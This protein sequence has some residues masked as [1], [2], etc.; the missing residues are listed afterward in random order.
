MDLCTASGERFVLEQAINRGGEAQIWTIRQDPHL[1]AKIY[2]K[3]TADHQAKLKAMLAAPLIRQGSHPAVAW[4]LDLLYGQN[5]FVGYLM[6]RANNCRP[7]FHYYNPARRQRLTA[8]QDWPR[9][10]HY[11]AAN[12]AR[13]V[14]TVHKGGHVIGDLNESNVL[15]T[16]TALVTLVDTDSFQIQQGGQSSQRAPSWLGALPGQQIYRCGVGKAEYTAPELQGVDFKTIDRTVAHDNFGLAVLI[17]YLLMDGFHP[18]AGVLNT[19][20]SVGRV[21]LYGI[22]QGLFPYLQWGANAKQAIQPP[23]KAP[24]FSYLHPGVQDAFRRTFVDGH[25]NP[26]RRVTAKEWKE[27]LQ[28][29]QEALV[30]CPQNTGHLYSRHLRHCPICAPTLVKQ[31][32]SPPP[33]IIPA[34]AQ[35]VTISSGPVLALPAQWLTTMRLSTGPAL[36]QLLALKPVLSQ[37]VNR[38]HPRRVDW[39]GYAK[40]VQSTLVTLPERLAAAGQVAVTHAHLLGGWLLSHLIGTPVAMM[41]TAGGARLLPQL[42][43][44]A[45]LTTHTQAMLL[46]VL[47]ALCFALCQ[48]YALR[49]TILPAR[50][51]CYAWVV[52]ATISGAAIGAVAVRL[53]GPAWD[54]VG[55]W[56]AEANHFTLITALFGLTQGLLQSVLLRHHLRLA[57]DGRAW[58]VVNGIGAILTAQGWLWGAALPLAWPITAVPDWQINAG[59]GAVMGSGV[60]SLLSGSVLIWMVRGTRP[61]FRLRHFALQLVRWS[62]K[63]TKL[64]KDAYRWG[65]AILLL[66]LLW[67]LLQLL[68]HLR[69]LS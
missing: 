10:L 48:A 50:Y 52:G 57:D 67:S 15:V 20:M 3:P 46:T 68:T 30:A 29:A 5:N 23:P 12:L 2:H 41:A 21:D 61:D 49:R 16:N 36:N 13:A 22:K 44:F 56:P 51:L 19:G 38:F 55:A 31:R 24:P 42:E 9:F 66:L 18:F 58:T 54:Q 28:E 63:P 1:V 11:T 34:L 32:P 62:V 37:A 45:P 60:G 4:P 64:R 40:T 6:P 8:R 35:S 65:R 39:H 14:S 43:R 59:L 27:I 7:L 26:A 33:A 47:F 69:N 25:A 53:L 17:F